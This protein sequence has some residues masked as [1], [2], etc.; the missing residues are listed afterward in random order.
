[1]LLQI[2]ES[3]KKDV[4]MDGRKNIRIEEDRLLKQVVNAVVCA[5]ICTET[6][7]P[8]TAREIE[9]PLVEHNFDL[10]PFREEKWE[11]NG[12]VSCLIY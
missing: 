9:D 8:F 12:R 5:S 10:T 11:W 4:R 3:E 6:K 1:M 2:L 7:K